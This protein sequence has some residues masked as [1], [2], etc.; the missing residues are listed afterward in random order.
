M[1][2]VLASTRSS[3]GSSP[4]STASARGLA[5]CTMSLSLA[6]PSGAS[7]SSL[8][9]LPVISSG[10]S[11]ASISRH[12]AKAS[13][14]KMASPSP[15]MSSRPQKAMREPFLVMCSLRVVMTAATFTSLSGEYPLHSERVLMPM[16]RRSRT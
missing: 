11:P 16:R 7:W 1:A 8:P 14:K 4:A 15:A 9:I 12:W 3:R 10:A 2:H 6:W 13:G 5:D